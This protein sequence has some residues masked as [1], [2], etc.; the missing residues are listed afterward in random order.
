[1]ANTRMP[2]GVSAG[3]KDN[4]S[5]TD[6]NSADLQEMQS[7][8]DQP[9]VQFTLIE[10]SEGLATKL[11]SLDAD[12]NLHKKSAGQIY[13]G[14][15]RRARARGIAQ[16]MQGRAKLG[17]N[18][19]LAYGV[20]AAE[21]ARIVTQRALSQYHDA[22]ARDRGHFEYADG[23]PGILFFDYDPPH[24]APALSVK[25]FDEVLCE[26]FPGLADVERAY[27]PSASSYIYTS[28]G[29]ELIGAGGLRCYVIVDD[30]SMIPEIG[31]AVYQ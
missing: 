12:G 5:C 13:N 30:A 23:E 29:R 20:T 16:F 18:Q 25:E 7:R 4:S 14:T 22:I 8:C 24:G 3:H 6:R 31:A 21:E 11:F 28:D 15:A 10:N 26:A 2:D 27:A 9:L 19:A 1:M 17:P